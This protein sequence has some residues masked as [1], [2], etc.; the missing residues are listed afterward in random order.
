MP[1]LNGSEQRYEQ[2]PKVSM[3]HC[4]GWEMVSMQES[5]ALRPPPQRLMLLPSLSRAKPS[6]EGCDLSISKREEGDRQSR[7]NK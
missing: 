5:E 2:G 1:S 3:R 4:V 7:L 6:S